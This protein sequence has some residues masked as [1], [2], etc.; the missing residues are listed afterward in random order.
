MIIIDNRGC[1]TSDS[2]ADLRLITAKFRTIGRN[3]KKTHTGGVQIVN[4]INA[5]MAL[6]ANSRRVGPGS[7]LIMLLFRLRRTPPICVF[8][9]FRPIVLNLAVS[10]YNVNVNSQEPRWTHMIF[11]CL[12]NVRVFTTFVA[13]NAL[14]M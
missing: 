6:S 12:P 2:E 1:Q 11:R 13:E 8:F 14:Q 9:R 3:R 5:K 4:Q 10:R 7:D